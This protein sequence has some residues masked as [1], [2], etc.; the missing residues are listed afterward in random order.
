VKS[1]PVFRLLLTGLARENVVDIACPPALQTLLRT[2]TPVMPESGGFERWLCTTFGAGS[3]QTLPAAP[4]AASGDGLPA[5]RGYWLYASPVQLQLQRDSFAMEGVAQGLSRSQ[6]DALVAALNAHFSVDGLIFYAPRADVWFVR[7][8]HAPDLS[9]TPLSDVLGRNIHPHLPKGGEAMLWHRRLN[10]IQMLL[11]QHPVNAAREQSGLPPVNS[12]W[13]WG[14][15]QHQ[16]LPVH[17]ALKVWSDD[18]LA[19]GL[20][21]A[22]GAVAMGLPASM[23]TLLAQ[24]LPEAG[25]LILPASA[26]QSS[27]SARAARWDEIDRVW[28]LPLLE[29][30]RCGSLARLELLLAGP[31]AVRGYV[32]H[33]ASLFKFW[34]RSRP[35]ETYLG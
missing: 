2:A 1:A 23:Q 26:A 15:G 10:E 29:A 13:F 11:H 31:A 22:A 17:P 21:R 14:G 7:L 18:P 5:E 32:L 12:L 33:R 25:L 16:A 34:R 6:V 28:L 20:A 19:L 3:Q 9:T 30:L 24:P 27:P 4:Y 8:D 35:L